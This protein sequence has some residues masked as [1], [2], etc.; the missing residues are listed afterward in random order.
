MR[1]YGKLRREEGV[2][3]LNKKNIKILMGLIVFT[4]VFCSAVFHMNVVW[5]I[6]GFLLG[7][8]MPL[9]LGF[10]IAFVLNVPMNFFEK[11]V[12]GRVPWNK[13]WWRKAIRPLSIVVTFAFIILLIMFLVL[14]VFTRNVIIYIYIEVNM[15]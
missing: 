13:P 4:V 9:I 12:L 10:S 7:L 14:L 6:V 8:I 1:D 2:L 15:M 5:N 3:E 11:K